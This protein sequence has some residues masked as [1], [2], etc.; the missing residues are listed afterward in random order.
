MMSQLGK[1]TITVQ[2]LRN[3]SRSKDNWKMKFAQLIEYNRNIFLKNHAQNVVEKLFPDLFLKNQKYF[4]INSSNFY[5][6]YFYC[7]S[8]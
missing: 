5:T 3:I 6:V 1:Q 8:V 2:I 7:M 4:W